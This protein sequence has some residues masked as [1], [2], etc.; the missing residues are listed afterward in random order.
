MQTC[1]Q[2]IHDQLK[3]LPPLPTSLPALN[4]TNAVLAKARGSLLAEDT[5]A[6]L[7]DSLSSDSRTVREAALKVCCCGMPFRAF[8]THRR[9]TWTQ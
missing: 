3:R 6:L 5:I 9:A 7:R 4:A 2:A 8:L 1:V